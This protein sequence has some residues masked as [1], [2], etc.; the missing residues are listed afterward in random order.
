[1]IRFLK[2]QA[3]SFIATAVDFAVT[4]F[5]KE[6][7]KFW[8]L[9]AS[10]IGTFSGGINP[11]KGAYSVWKISAGMDRQSGTECRRGICIDKLYRVE[12]YR[13][14]DHR[15]CVSRYFL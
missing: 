11:G 7:L 15:V 12:L 1:M 2:A 5:L 4:V 3:S 13:I 8:Y 10:F 14:K 9:L 6:V